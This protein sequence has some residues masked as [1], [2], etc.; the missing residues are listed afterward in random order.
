MNRWLHE[1]LLHFVLLGGL[2]FGAYSL[3]D[4][5]AM[6][7]S[8]VVRISAAEVDWLKHTWS[9]QWQR[10]PDESELRGLVTGYLKE[11][12]LA[13]EARAL[14]LA[15][16]DTVVRRRLAQ[17]MEFLVEDTARLAEPAEEVLRQYFAEHRSQYLQPSIISFIQLYF[18]TEASAREALKV[19]KQ[20][21]SM[22]VG[23]RSLLP[24]ENAQAD[25]QTVANLFGQQFA[26][27]I[28]T[29]EPNGW[30]GPV[31]SAHGFHLVHI[32]D[33]QPEQMY[34]FE[35]I[36]AQVL[37]DWYRAQQAR[38]SAQFLAALYKKY[39]VIV[40]KGIAP[41]IGPLGEEAQ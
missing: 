19:L 10:P 21:P 11:I 27:E 2:L 15:E 38:A 12:L 14:G 41:L 31:V 18:N 16:N 29:L 39:D 36:R 30:Q 26:S 9:G 1:P 37:D 28:F 5:D 8:Q 40:D 33:A 32:H 25:E 35:E 24:R 22:Q 34:A 23:E 7:T 20:N 17:K 3:L 13:R 4:R 6:D